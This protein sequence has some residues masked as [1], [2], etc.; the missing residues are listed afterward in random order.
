MAGASPQAPQ[1]P[2]TTAIVLASVLGAGLE[3]HC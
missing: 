2:R 3:L 1:E